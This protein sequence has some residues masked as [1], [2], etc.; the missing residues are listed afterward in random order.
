M[1]IFVDTSALIALADKAAALGPEDLELL[2]TAAYLAG[3]DDDYL[4][5]LERAHQARIEAQE[6]DAVAAE[7][8]ERDLEPQ[9]QLWHGQGVVAR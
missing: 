4:M 1:V 6:V 9:G 7:R 5:T 2:A 3:H 8:R